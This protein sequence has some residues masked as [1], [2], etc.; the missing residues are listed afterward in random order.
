[1]LLVQQAFDD[2]GQWYGA[3]KIRITLAEGGIRVSTKRIAAIMQE[4]DLRS[5]RPDSKKQFK[6]YQKYREQN[7]LEQQFATDRPNQT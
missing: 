7:L 1:M 5:I 2:S 6:K 4:H 3:E